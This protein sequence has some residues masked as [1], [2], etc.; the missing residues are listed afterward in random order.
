[1]GLANMDRLKAEITQDKQQC[2]L[3]F[4]VIDHKIKS[5]SELLDQGAL[6]NDIF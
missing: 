2:Q 1:M 4:E 6:I 3:A 5:I